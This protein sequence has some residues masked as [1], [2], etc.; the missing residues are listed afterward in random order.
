MRSLAKG[1][2][3]Q[4]DVVTRLVQDSSVADDQLSLGADR[5]GA[6]ILRFPFGPDGYLR[7][8]ALASSGGIG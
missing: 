3:D 2:V 1:E 7:K 8:V 4:V 5:S 6:S